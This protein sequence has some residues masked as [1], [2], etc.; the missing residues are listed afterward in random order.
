M[1]RRLARPI[2]KTKLSATC[3]PAHRWQFRSRAC[4]RQEPTDST[5]SRCRRHRCPTG[6]CCWP[7]PRDGV[8]GLNGYSRCPRAGPDGWIQSWSLGGLKALMKA[9][10]RLA[11][12]TNKRG[13]AAPSASGIGGVAAAH[14][15]R[16]RCSGPGQRVRPL[17]DHQHRETRKT[18]EETHRTRMSGVLVEA[19]QE[20]RF[21]VVHLS[22]SGVGFVPRLKEGCCGPGAGGQRHLW[23]A[24]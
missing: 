10:S 9:W 16:V 21:V 20:V 7:C 24:V 8:K 17:E 3:K 6:T 1:G 11:T 12:R 13:S 2:R 23:R 19:G 15:D 14:F 5:R 18:T 22:G 4:H